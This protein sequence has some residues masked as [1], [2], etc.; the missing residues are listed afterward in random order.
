MDQDIQGRIKQLIDEE[1]RLRSAVGEGTM[2][3]DEEHARLRSIETELDQCWDL[4]RQRRA[5]RQ[6]GENPDDA[7]ARSEDVVEKYLG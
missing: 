7:A 4:L 5:K 3:A 1:H 2:T 6:Y